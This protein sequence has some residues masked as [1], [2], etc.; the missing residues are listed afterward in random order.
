MN[1]GANERSLGGVETAE[2]GWGHSGSSSSS[3]TVEATPSKGQR[4]SLCLSL[5]R[6]F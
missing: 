5:F 3:G 6:C 1:F 4:G 2:Q